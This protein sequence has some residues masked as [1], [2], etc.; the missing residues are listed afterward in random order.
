MKFNHFCLLA[1]MLLIVL[2]MSVFA[3]A[4]CATNDSS[5]SDCIDNIYHTNTSTTTS[6]CSFCN[7]TPST[8][9]TC[10]TCSACDP[11]PTCSTCGCPLPVNG[12]CGTDVNTCSKGTFADVADS[13]TLYKWNCVG[14]HSGTT[15]NCTKDKPVDP[16]TTDLAPYILELPNKTITY[17]QNLRIDLWDYVKDS[18]DFQSELEITNL[19]I[20]DINSESAVCTVA[21]NRYLSCNGNDLGITTISVNVEDSCGKHASK[22]FDINVTNSAPSIY[23]P[24]QEVDCVQNVNKLIDLYDYSS[25]EDKQLLDFN[26]ISQSNPYF[27]NCYLTENHFL[28]CAISSCSD[29][30]NIVQVR[31]TDIF[32]LY[33]E[34]TFMLNVK[35]KTPVW[36]NISSV[37]INESKTK[38][39]D[40]RNYV[41][42]T[43][44]KNNLTFHFNQTSVNGLSC[45]LVDSNFISCTLESNDK[46]SVV[47]D[48]SATDSK[49]KSSST[50][51]TV[52]SN[53]FDSNNGVIHFSAETYGVCLETCS[54]YSLPI[55]LK[56]DTNAK[57]CFDFDSSSSPYNYLN[58]SL[59]QNKLCLN[60]KE[61]TNITL[62]VN[63][64]GAEERKYNVSVFDNDSNLSMDFKFEVGTCSNFD[65]FKIEEFD[66]TVCAGERKDVSVLVKNTTSSSKKIYL[67]AD[68]EMV[69]PHFDNEYITLNGGEQKTVQLT[70]NAIALQAGTTESVSISGDADSYHIEKQ[71]YFDVVDCSNIVKRTFTLSAPNVCFDVKRGQTLESQFSVRRESNSGSNCSTQRKDF[72]LNIA[73]ASSE[74]SYSTVSLKE[75]EGKTILYSLIVP[76]DISAGKNYVTINASDGSEW[77][78]FTQTKDICLNVLPESSSSFYVKTQAKDIIWCGS[79]IFD[80][81][82]V[83]NGDLDETYSLSA[84]EVPTGVNVSFSEDRF[85]VRKGTSKT[86]F[87]SVSTNPSSIVGDN[88]KIQLKLNGSTQLTSTIYFNVKE[89]TTFDDLQILSATSEIDIKGNSSASFD[90]VVRN[91]SE[92]D[93]NNIKITI[94]SLPD[95]VSMDDIVIPSL[96]AGELTNVSGK[97][98]ALDVNGDYS[99][100]FVVSSSQLV[101]K[102]GFTL[103]I[104]K[105][106]GVFAGMFSAF[107]SFGGNNILDFSGIMGFVIL[108]IILIVL[109]WL[110][111]LGLAIITKPKQREV[112]ME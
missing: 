14:L 104:E 91:N 30:N 3:N 78:S 52:S 59:S 10:S 38:F 13:S 94:E 112:W 98:T 39:V 70:I 36:N 48:L 44:D 53:C 84:F 24:N 9:S 63:S 87:V 7:S 8:C 90:L 21:S 17:K 28:F 25:D 57:K 81:E 69:L 64:C 72:F 29:A 79:S 42:D 15:A 62:S 50:S 99:P 20:T 34:T 2:S 105:N 65:G 101:N 26:I 80:V 75:G 82:I 102:K 35:N 41:T 60:S 83:N 19:Y 100:V 103:H 93:L 6:T 22:Q 67:S 51:F 68:N 47:L 61:E 58:T 85:T 32:G 54:T 73:Q 89:K 1:G 45:S 56:N 108:A 18:D 109:V 92:K 97:I 5:C 16:C 74:L 95:G 4:A 111:T 33:S 43:E 40:L 76:T 66:G 110:I 86:I 23:I 55:Y 96:A 46:L 107:F 37:C 12:V 77:D 11:A 88:Q 71:V 27:A 31:A 49:G 106:N